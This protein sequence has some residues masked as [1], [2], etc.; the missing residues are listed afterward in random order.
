VFKA[1]ISISA[2]TNV[3]AELVA[4]QTSARAKGV[5][6]AELAN[7]LESADTLI[8]TFVCHA[9]DVE[10]GGV[11]MDVR[12]TLEGAGYHVTFAVE[13]Q[14]KGVKKKSGPLSWLLRT[15]V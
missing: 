3:E 10:A 6:E 15:N 7:L 9:T 5:S 1:H 14:G 8:S 12:K 11:S 2:T 13:V 4:L